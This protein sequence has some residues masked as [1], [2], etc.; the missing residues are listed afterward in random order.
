MRRLAAAG[1]LAPGL[2]LAQP[3]P[4]PRATPPPRE[5]TALPSEEELELLQ[6]LE[7][8]DGVDEAD[9]ELLLAPTPARGADGGS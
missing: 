2:L 7:L 5:A 4:V 3:R 6:F 8:L 9:A 1:L